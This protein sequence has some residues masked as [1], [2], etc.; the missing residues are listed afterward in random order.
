MLGALPGWPASSH[1]T[2]GE[3]GPTRTSSPPR[4]ARD[5][6]RS[7]P[8]QRLITGCFSARRPIQPKGGPDMDRRL[9]VVGRARE[10]FGDRLEDVL[11]MARQDRQELRGWQ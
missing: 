1:G 7:F 10:F 5:R 3:T 6:R 9:L 8:F 11:H 2:P 4:S